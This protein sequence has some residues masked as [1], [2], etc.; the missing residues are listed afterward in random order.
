M[1]VFRKLC[2]G[3]HFRQQLAALRH[4]KTKIPIDALKGKQQGAEKKGVSFKKQADKPQTFLQ[5]FEANF[6]RPQGQDAYAYFALTVSLFTITAGEF[7]RKFF[8]QNDRSAHTI[9]VENESKNENT[10][11]DKTVSEKWWEWAN[12][13]TTYP[14][15]AKPDANFKSLIQSVLTD[16]GADFS[17]SGLGK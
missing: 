1:F 16:L 4:L 17:R 15:R 14:D 10:I 13:P 9:V 5:I 12:T 8:S 6:A 7:M 11:D 3:K 2:A